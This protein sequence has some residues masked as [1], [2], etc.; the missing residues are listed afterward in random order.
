MNKWSRF[1]GIAMMSTALLLSGCG[2][3]EQASQAPP[4]SQSEP[5][6]TQSPA[7]ASGEPV[8]GGT[9]TRAAIYGDPQNLDPIIRSHSTSVS[10]ITW[11]IFEPL[12]RYDAVKGEFVPANAESWEISEDGKTYT[13]HLRKGVRFHNGREVVAGDFKYSLE[14]LLNPANASPNAMS[15]ASVLGAEEFIKGTGKDVPGIKVIDDS[16]LQFTLKGPDNTFLGVLSLP[17]TSAVPK[18]AVD[19]KGAKFGE[20]PVGAGPFK[21]TKWVRD[22]EVELTA[23]DDYYNGRPYLDKVVY[24]IMTDQSARDNAFASK[25]LDMMVLGDAQYGRLKNDPAMKDNLVEVAELFTRNMKFNFKKDGPWQDVRV[26]QAINYAID[27]DTI[28]KTVLQDKAYPTVGILPTSILGFNDKVTTY[29][30]DPA[31]A[32]QLLADAGYANGFSVKILTTNHPAFGLPAVEAIAGYLKEVGI[33]LV[34]EQ[35]DFA[36][37]TDRMNAGDFELAITSNGGWTN[38][39]EYLSKYFHSRNAGASGNVGS[40]K[41]EKVDAL[42]DQ[43]ITKTDQTEMIKLAQEAEDLVMKDAPWW[44]FNYNKAVIAHQPWVKG[45]QPVPTDIDYQ[46]LTKVWIDPSLKK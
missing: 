39:V 2:K 40:Y 29:R 17:Y 43:A 3:T 28:I 22:S 5:G 20:E 41:N 21:L 14:R 6:G 31:Q 27:R 34:P 42:L 12:I 16:T 24:K 18:E 23:F 11:N 33:T 13:F 38:P 4:P 8:R 30:Y 9:L 7:A 37:A 15:M 10:M 26:R 45:L 36:T 35:V 46:D 1:I 44:P 25:Q 32:K 19:E